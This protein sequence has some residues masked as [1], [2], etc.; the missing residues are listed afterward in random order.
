MGVYLE[1]V[2]YNKYFILFKSKMSGNVQ[3]CFY[4]AISFYSIWRNNFENN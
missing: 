1:I 4:F 3:H 2:F